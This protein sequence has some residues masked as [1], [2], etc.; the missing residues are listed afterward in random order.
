MK[1]LRQTSVLSLFGWLRGQ[2]DR[3]W[4]LVIGGATVLG[5]YSVAYAL[6]RSASDAALVGLTNLYRLGLA[7]A[8]FTTPAIQRQLRAQVVR[9]M[10]LS[11]LCLCMAVVTAVCVEYFWRSP[12]WS[13]SSRI[14]PILAFSVFASSV[15]WSINATLNHTGESRSLY[16]IQWL[17]MS[18]AV[19][20]GILLAHSIFVGAIA[21]CV[22]EFVGSLLGALAARRYL[23]ARVLFIWLVNC[24]AGGIACGSATWFLLE[25]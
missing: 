3:L 21:V 7:K 20:V 9:V 19:V 14:V 4:V 22:R 1:D 24:G 2:S 15:S 18:L 12:S 6:A 25:M 10:V 8:G 17:E 5:I 23:Q 16:W 13:G 11:W